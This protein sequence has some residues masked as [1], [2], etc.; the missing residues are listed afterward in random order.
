VVAPVIQVLIDGSGPT[1]EAPLGNIPAPQANLM[2]ALSSAIFG[3]GLQDQALLI[4]IGA[5]LAVAL[6]VVDTLLQRAGS[7]FRTPVMPVAVGIY[8]PVGLSVPI[9]VGG[10]A[11]WV[12]ERFYAGRARRAGSTTLANRWRVLGD[13]GTRAGILFASGLIAGEAIL[14]ILTAFLAAQGLNLGFTAHERHDW[15]GIV[16]LLY[17]VVL[18]GYVALRPGL[19]RNATDHPDAQGTPPPPRAGH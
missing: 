19:R 18:T 3:E 7:T 13:V 6:I 9:F 11:A 15:A 4:W 12:A 17:L 14:G 10:V 8:L 2:Y 1:P 16:L 5:G